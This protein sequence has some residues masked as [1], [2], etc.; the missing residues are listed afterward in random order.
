[1]ENAWDSVFSAEWD[2]DKH[3]GTLTLVGEHVNPTQVHKHPH[4]SVF[5]EGVALSVL[6]QI[7]VILGDENTSTHTHALSCLRLP[8][9]INMSFIYLKR[10]HK[11]NVMN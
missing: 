4:K 7:L 3:R 2:T 6:M 11:G 8:K 9:R 5:L 10:L 1:M